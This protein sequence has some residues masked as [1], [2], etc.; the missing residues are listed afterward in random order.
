MNKPTPVLTTARLILRPLRLADAP[1]IQ[2]VFP[3]WEILK[4]MSAAIPWPY[5][6][7]GAYTY[8]TSTLPKIAAG[9]EYGWAITLKSEGS[10]QLIGIISLYPD[11]EENRGFWLAEEYHKNGLM[12]EAVAAVTD[13]AFDELGMPS[14]KLNNAEPNTASHRLKE[15]AGAK[16][17]AID[18]NVDYI[19]GK[20]RQIRWL[21]TQQQWENNRRI[22]IGA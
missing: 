6:E 22:F 16:I 2:Q 13:F 5:P 21:L 18:D 8:L 7:D 19:G 15:K 20:F 11:R 1:Q 10:D 14:L 4:Y 17:V 12:T 9:Q 3:H